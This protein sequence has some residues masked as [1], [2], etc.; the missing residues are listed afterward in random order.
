MALLAL[1]RPYP[2]SVKLEVIYLNRGPLLEQAEQELPTHIKA[3]GR[4]LGLAVGVDRIQMQ[5]YFIRCLPWVPS[6][7]AKEGPTTDHLLFPSPK[8]NRKKTVQSIFPF[9]NNVT[10]GLKKAL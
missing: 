5:M 2:H 7:E 1:G 9:Q 6:F 3:F 4:D 8:K 10:K